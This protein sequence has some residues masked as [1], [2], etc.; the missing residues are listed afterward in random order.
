MTNTER[1]HM[2]VENKEKQIKEKSYWN[3]TISPQKHFCMLCEKL[4]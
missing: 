4:F 3:Q 1:G 2:V